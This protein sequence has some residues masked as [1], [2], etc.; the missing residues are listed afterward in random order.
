MNVALDTNP[1]Y[2]S[3]AGV[4]RY[5]R[6]LIAGIKAI[7][8][9]D[10]EFF[11]LAWPVDNFSYRQPMRALKTLYRECVWTNVVAPKRLQEKETLLLHETCPL[12]IFPPAS[13]KRVLTLHD[14]AVLRYPKRFRKWQAFS[15][16]IR[17]RSIERADRIICVSEFTAHEA[18]SLLGIPSQKLHVVYNGCHFQPNTAPLV[19]KELDFA[20]PQE[21]FLFVGS[22]EPGKN[23]ALL[24]EAYQLAEEQGIPLPSLLIVGTRWKGVATEG[25]PPGNWI[26]LGSQPD[27]ILAHLYRSAVAL[28]FPSKYEGFGLPLVEAMALGCPVVCSPVASLPE[29]GGN[30]ALFTELEPASYLDAMRK[31]CS[32]DSLRA[33]LIEKGKHQ[34]QK[35]SWA[36]CARETIEVYKAVLNDG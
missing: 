14:L 32:D 36:K 3:Q 16:K 4:A 19:E 1:L 27:S 12:Y 5:L 18:T 15:T 34:A 22:L 25:P 31:L 20:V 9:P 24:K 29:V 30:A 35:F 6:G 8:P 13:V 33:D 7:A 28:L 11:E 2:T 21:Y 26:Y 23:L 17:L 10:F